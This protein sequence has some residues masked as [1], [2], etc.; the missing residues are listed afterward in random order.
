LG[1]SLAHVAMI[2]ES[3]KDKARNEEVI[4]LIDIGT[5]EDVY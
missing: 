2:A 3:F 1:Y 4:M 5:H